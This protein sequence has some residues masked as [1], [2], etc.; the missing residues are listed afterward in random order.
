[1]KITKVSML[2]VSVLLMVVPVG[3]AAGSHPIAQPLKDDFDLG[4][5]SF[6]VERESLRIPTDHLVLGAEHILD[7][8][9]HNGGFGWEHADC[10]VTYHNI[11]GPILLGVLGTY[12]HTRDPADLVG[13]LNG[14]A[15]DLA[16]T[17]DNGE[18][19]FGSFTP[20]FMRLL[21]S[22]SGNTTFSD[23]AA[24]G[25]FG[26]LDAATYGPDDLDTAGWIAA[27]E[28]HRSGVWVNLR[29]WE[30]HNLIET[31]SILGQ[32]GQTDLFEQAVLDGL[33]TLDN[34]DPDNVYSDIIG[35]AGAVQGLAFA[36]RY[37][38]PAISAPLHPGIHGIDNLE[39]LAAYLASLQNPNGSWYWHSNLVAPATGDEDVQTTAYAVMA[40]LEIDVMTAASYQPATEV[41]RNWIHSLQLPDGGFP[42][43]PGSTENTEIEGEA[44]TAIAAFD[45]RIFVDGFETGDTTL[46]ESVV[47]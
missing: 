30:F 43:A 41:A 13:A 3:E 42:Q 27:V 5:S 46:W 32:A 47:P 29:A 7:Q 16:Y 21:A 15:F 25:F 31:A 36:R 38:F 22:A 24:T 35:L 12:N 11:T 45:A 18:A 23:H 14:G 4:V 37:T 1:M 28:T 33:M 40:L 19:R 44:L 9:C 34:S 8:Q 17:Y 6:A 39:D 20:T 26:A 10:S 2:V